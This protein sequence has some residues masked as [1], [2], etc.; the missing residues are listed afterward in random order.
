MNPMPVMPARHGAHRLDDRALVALE[1]EALLDGLLRQEMHLLDGQGD[2]FRLRALAQTGARA[3]EAVD[4]VAEDDD[5]G[6]QLAALAVGL[7]ADDRRSR[8][9]PAR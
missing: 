3:D 8:L 6:V 5:V 1:I 4:A 2:V 9:S 7:H